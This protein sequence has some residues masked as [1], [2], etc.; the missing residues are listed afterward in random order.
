MGVS[1]NDSCRMEGWLYLIR[2]NRFGLQYSRKRYFILHDLV[3]KSYKSNPVSNNEL[4]MTSFRVAGIDHRVPNIIGFC[5]ITD[6]LNGSV[7]SHPLPVFAHLSPTVPRDPFSRPLKRV[8]KLLWDMVDS[9]KN[10]PVRSAIIDSCIRV[11]DNGRESIQRKVVF[12]FTLYNASNH[13]DQL[14]LGANSPEEAAR[15]IQALQEA[16]LKADM[17]KRTAVDC[18]RRDSQ[19][20]RLNCSNK[21]H[22]LN[23][24]DW[25]FCSSSVRDAMT[26]DV[27]A[28]SSW[29][30]FGCHNGLRLFEEAK[31]RESH[32]KW[33]DHPAIM[34]VGVVDGTSEAIFQ[35]LMSLGPSRSEWDFCYYKG[36]VI[37][38]L[39]GHTDIVHKLLRR[40][41]LPWS[42]TCMIF[43]LLTVCTLLGFIIDK[44]CCRSM[45]KR[46]LLLR[47]Y[48][49]REDDGT[50]VILYHSVFHQKC[51]CQKG[52]VRACLKSGGYVISP[53]NQRKQSVVKHMLAIDW[54]FW[55]S[56][57]RTSSARCITIHMLGRLAALRELFIA[58]LGDCSSSYFLEE[59]VR[60]KTLH[61]IEEVKVEIQT[62]LENGKN[63]A[64]MEEEEEVA[65]A[66]SE[67]A[68]LMGLND[69]SDEFFDVSEPLDYDQSENG[70]PSDFGSEMYSQDT[71]HARL[72]SAA[73]FVKKLHDLAVQ[74]RG[75]VDL[76]EKAKE[77]TLVCHYGSTLPKDP[78]CNLPCSWSQT[79]PST[80]LIRG[81][82]YLKDRKKASRLVVCCASVH[83]IFRIKAKGTLMQMVAADWLKSDKR[84]DDLGGRPGGI[85][86]KYAAKGGP[87]FFFIVN[88]QVP[89]STTYTLALYYMMDT[90]IENVPLL[91]SFV[92]GDDAYRN[93][94][95]KLIPYISKITY[96]QQQVVLT[97]EKRKLNPSLGPWIVKQS[98]GKKACLVGPA[99]EIN[100]FRGKNYLELL[101]R[102]LPGQEGPS[103]AGG[104]MWQFEDCLYVLMSRGVVSL[105]VGYLNNLVIEMAFLVQANTPEEL[106]EYL[107]G[108]CRLNH[109][110]VSKAVQVKP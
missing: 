56:Y 46:D 38:H 2:S 76:H 75:Y 86:Q 107:L 55:K 45:K 103:V 52:Y 32:G 90:P 97:I 105:V 18:P 54:R 81:E 50:Y 82:T 63:M 39:D 100:Y 88:I 5:T 79:D 20:L 42:G 19:S 23:S 26:S 57:L 36:S 72:S 85:V 41:W 59:Q 67:H 43:T 4:N 106:P 71:R 84:E 21:S 83:E 25:T 8:P 73:G 15:W 28:P 94:R 35:T 7:T 70:W 14:K 108:T 96:A 33:D 104:F 22:P 3:L 29:T 102:E 58:K 110:D 13:N 11:T 10:D 91:E 40:D 49:R 62:K 98:V 87:E 16:A 48:W 89:G 99:L 24:I 53:V 61:Q 44:S 12:I 60:N 37:E 95:F 1:Q 92:K 68:S 47:R 66:P 77:D 17:N 74:K 9:Y 27:V 30:I 6:S 69:A 101:G 78:T 80:F 65:K 64:D 93:S 51:P 31:D 34:A 109:L